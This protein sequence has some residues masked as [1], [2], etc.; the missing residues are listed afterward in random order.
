MGA[1]LSAIRSCSPSAGRV[2]PPAA[3][4]L[5]AAEDDAHRVRQRLA[6]L[7]ILDRQDLAERS[8]E[9]LRQ[10]P[11]RELLRA[12]IQQDDASRGIGCDHRIADAAQ[13]DGEPFLLLFEL[14]GSARHTVLEIGVQLVQVAGAIVDA[15][16]SSR[17][18]ASSFQTRQW[19][20]ATSPAA[21]AA[22][23]RSAPGAARA[24][25]ADADGQSQAS[26]PDPV[27]VRRLTGT[28]SR[29]RKAIWV[30]QCPDR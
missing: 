16:S 26:L 4:R 30:T 13:R 3:P 24:T 17:R 18:T 21:A 7:R 6:R 20:A 28:R 23:L 19:N 8:A 15:R 12:A 11:A 27:V 5:L 9:C 22:R 29:P 10:R 14:D 25:G 2:A 1:A